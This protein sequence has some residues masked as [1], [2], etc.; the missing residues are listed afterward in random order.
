MRDCF[1]LEYYF[2][3]INLTL[4]VFSVFKRPSFLSL[5]DAVSTLLI[6]YLYESN[7]HDQTNSDYMSVIKYTIILR[8]H[9]SMETFIDRL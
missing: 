6:D 5:L 2:G 3:I 9:I 8:L 1:S 4:N 7:W